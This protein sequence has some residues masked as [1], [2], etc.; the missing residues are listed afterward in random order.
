MAKNS[1]PMNDASRNY[2]DGND[3][4]TLLYQDTTLLVELL[5]LSHQYY[6]ERSVL[7]VFDRIQK[8]KMIDDFE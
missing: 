1:I 7:E 2:R 3:Q 5:Q 4:N 8:E 6:K